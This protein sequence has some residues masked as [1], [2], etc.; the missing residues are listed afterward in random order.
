MHANI[1]G[2]EFM[3]IKNAAHIANIEQEAVFNQAMMN[4]LKKHGG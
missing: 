3:L 2:S 1:K 4:F